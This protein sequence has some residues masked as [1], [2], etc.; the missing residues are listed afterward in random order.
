MAAPKKS[1]KRRIRQIVISVNLAATTM[2]H[3]VEL[4]RLLR[5]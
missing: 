1:R 5:H 3:I 4:I 2:I